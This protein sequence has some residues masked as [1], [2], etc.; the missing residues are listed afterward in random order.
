MAFTQPAQC[1]T[2]IF[3]TVRFVVV[4]IDGDRDDD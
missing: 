3:I 2:P 4:V 1:I